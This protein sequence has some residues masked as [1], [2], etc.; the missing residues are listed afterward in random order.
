MERINEPKLYPYVDDPE[1]FS[2]TKP[3]IAIYVAK[4]EQGKSVSIKYLIHRLVESDNISHGWVFTAT[5]FNHD[6]D[7]LPKGNVTH[8]FSVEALEKIMEYQ[9]VNT[10]K[11]PAF[12]IFDDIVKLVPWKNVIVTQFFMNFRHFNI[13][14]LIASQYFRSL[15]PSI[16]EQTNY[17]FI[18]GNQSDCGLDAIAK[19]AF[20]GVTKMAVSNIIDR[21][22]AKFVSIICDLNTDDRDMRYIRFKAPLVEGMNITKWWENTNRPANIAIGTAVAKPL[23]KKET[24]DPSVPPEQNTGK[25]FK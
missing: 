10:D 15:P 6:Y 8:K 20:A 5:D 9:K 22:R 24:V 25:Q 2:V 21:N 4:P 1:I 19:G 14:I 13:R 12:I 18:F 17:Y 23:T 16:R 7:Y 3:F 11:R